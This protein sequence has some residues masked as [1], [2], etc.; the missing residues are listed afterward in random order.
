MHDWT[1]LCT[2]SSFASAFAWHKADRKASSFAPAAGASTFAPEA[3]A[4][5]DGTEGGTEDGGLAGRVHSDIAIFAVVCHF[6]SKKYFFLPLSTFI[7]LY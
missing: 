6:V 3:G 4:T 7:H 1:R 2:I 5:A